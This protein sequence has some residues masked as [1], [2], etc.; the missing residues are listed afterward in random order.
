MKLQIC[1]SID[2]SLR[3][4]SA[5]LIKNIDVGQQGASLGLIWI[6]GADLRG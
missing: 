4:S 5:G 6:C 2:V 3:G 1:R